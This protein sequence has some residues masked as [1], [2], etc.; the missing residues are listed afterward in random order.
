MLRAPLPDEWKQ[1]APQAMRVAAERALTV[2]LG[3]G[4]LWDEQ[5][6]ET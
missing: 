6:E 5:P 4:P 2:P 1:H 3:E